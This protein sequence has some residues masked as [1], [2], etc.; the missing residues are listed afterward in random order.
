MKSQPNNKIILVGFMGTGKSIV[1]EKLAGQLGWS[2]VDIDEEI[3][4]AAKKPISKIFADDGE[5]AF[6]ELES[7]VLEAALASPEQA[8]VATGGGAVLRASNRQAMLAHGF[9][10][11]LKA[12]PETIIAR[13][14]NDSSRPLLQGD[15]RARVHELLEKRKDAYDFAHLAIDTTAM[16]VAEVVQRIAD[17]SGLISK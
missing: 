2:R 13:V 7:R 5:D 10:A 8:I 3:V 12:S 11:A 6:R 9:V 14:M 17:E 15:V 16:T 4:K 1:S